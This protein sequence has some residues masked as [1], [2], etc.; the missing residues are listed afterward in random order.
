MYLEMSD[1]VNLYVKQS[2]Y[3]IPCIF[4]ILGDSWLESSYETTI[5]RPKGKWKVRR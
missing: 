5:F 3:G 1:K 2:G 4:E